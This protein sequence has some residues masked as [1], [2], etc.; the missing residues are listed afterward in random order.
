MQIGLRFSAQDVDNFCGKGAILLGR[1]VQKGCAS[2]S[3]VVIPPGTGIP[4]RSPCGPGVVLV[5]SCC[6]LVVVLLCFVGRLV[7]LFG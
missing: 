6:G 4:L 2:F 1:K 5:W 3:R 7:G